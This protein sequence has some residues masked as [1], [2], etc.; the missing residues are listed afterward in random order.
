MDIE[1]ILRRT[2]LFK[3]LHDEP[4][5]ALAGV[6]QLREIAGGTCLMQE[7]EP[8]DSLY[9]V[10]TGRMRA[11]S[12]TSAEPTDIGV[13]EAIGEVG[14]AANGPRLATVHAVR[15]SVVLE[16]EGGAMLDALQP[17]P[18]AL[19]VVMQ[20]VL[21]R[22][23]R[24]LRRHHGP[25]SSPLKTLALLELHPGAGGSEFHGRLIEALRLRDEVCV[26]DAAAVDQ[27]LGAKASTW[28]FEDGAQNRELVR[29]LA[30]QEQLHD[31]VVL[32][33]GEG[34]SEW[35]QRC[36]RQADRILLLSE[37]DEPHMGR[38][39]GQLLAGLPTLAERELVLRRHREGPVGDVMR[40]R[41]DAAA[42]AHHYWRPG[43][44][45][46]VQAIARQLTGHG[47]GVVLSGGGAR[48]FAHI[49]LVRALN[50]LNIPVDLF[51]GSS[52]GSFIAAL[53]A[54][55]LS[56]R[57][58][59]GVCRENF[60]E[61]N[62]LNDYTLPRVSLI[63]GQRFLEGLRDIFGE[64]QIEALWRP[65]YAVSTNLTL[66]CQHAHIE[67]ELALWLAASMLIP[68]IAPP[69]GWK[70]NLHADGGIVNNLPTDVMHQR[71]RGPVL[72]CSV[73]TVGA[74]HCRGVEGPDPGVLHDWPLEEPR[75]SLFDI[76]T[77]TATLTSD[78]GTARRAEL[79][80][81]FLQMPVPRIGMFEF[82]PIDELVRTGYEFAMRTLLE[83]RALLLEPG[84]G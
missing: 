20:A 55:G 43:R 1:A 51:G 83:Q 77:R 74:V 27:A 16:L 46:D 62:L 7:G 17:Y 54:Q 65:Y 21:R 37:A 38:E 67:G 80:D 5:A 56:A 3:R 57:E 23:Q 2:A 64:Q 12:S 33:A 76:L 63:R 75:P 24:L 45:E 53:W 36:L 69:I 9:V 35:T 61:R 32:L 10:V 6:A 42:S 15:D 49:G 31:I 70:G 8:S 78:S 68:G 81:V 4:L 30:A 47:I 11:Q 18:G 29:W 52:M 71:A 14:V 40:L 26:I 58:M 79:A 34:S 28:P 72:A 22:M 60:V 19:F 13:H 48:G 50:E 84:Q 59:V 73:N 82:E 41:R 39:V 25:S 66:G 44:D